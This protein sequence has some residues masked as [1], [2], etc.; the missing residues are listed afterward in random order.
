MFYQFESWEEKEWSTTQKNLE[1]DVSSLF[2]ISLILLDL[3][4]HVVFSTT[5]LEMSSLDF[6]GFPS[7]R[8]TPC[9]ELVIVAGKHKGEKEKYTQEKFNLCFRKVEVEDESR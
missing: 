4:E 1:P 6:H 7:I 2:P 3:S 5:N 8:I 9:V